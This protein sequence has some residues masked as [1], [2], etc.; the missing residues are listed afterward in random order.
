M[1][2]E[3]TSQTIK[4]I[5]TIQCFL[6]IQ[7]FTG[8][9]T[10]S[11][12]CLNKRGQHPLP[13]QAVTCTIPESAEN[14][15]KHAL[16]WRCAFIF[17]CYR[18]IALQSSEGIHSEVHYSIN[19]HTHHQHT[20]N[21][22]TIHTVPQRHA[23]H[24]QPYM[25]LYHGITGHAQPLDIK[26]LLPLPDPNPRGTTHQRVCQIAPLSPRT[27]ERSPS[28]CIK[29]TRRKKTVQQLFTRH[30]AHVTLRQSSFPRG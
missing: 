14:G 27:T 28:N 26:S 5:R 8:H 6:W 30:W 17:K 3:V 11:W 9:R 2:R 21:T 13:P 19:T 4:S 24:H 23:C 18:Q 15:S 1:E 12:L 25:I 7:D 29:P 20:H 16:H 10:D 22:H